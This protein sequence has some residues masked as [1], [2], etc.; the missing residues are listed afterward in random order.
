MKREDQEAVLR[1]AFREEHL[2]ITEHARVEMAVE[3]VSTDDVIAAG[4]GAEVVEE[5][6][7]RPQGVTKVVLGYSPPD[8]T[9]AFGGQRRR[10]RIRPRSTPPARDG[11]STI[12]PSVARR[13]DE[14]MRLWRR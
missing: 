12:A 1:W 14:R 5:D 8:E 7:D 3:S 2:A 10:V 6:R 9:V 4:S 11:L 13:K